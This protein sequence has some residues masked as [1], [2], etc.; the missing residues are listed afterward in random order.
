MEDG[1]ND[2]DDDLRTKAR[3]DVA[4]PWL[5]RELRLYQRLCPSIGP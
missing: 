3:V 1:D 4:F 5:S 2:D